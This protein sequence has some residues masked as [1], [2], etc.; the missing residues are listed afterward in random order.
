MRPSAGTEQTCGDVPIWS[1]EM[2]LDDVG[3][4]CVKSLLLQSCFH[5]QPYLCCSH[6]H[7]IFGPLETPI[8]TGK[9]IKERLRVINLGGSRLVQVRSDVD[10]GLCNLAAFPA[11]PGRSTWV[12]LDLWV[13]NLL[14]VKISQTTD[15]RC[16]QHLPI[17]SKQKHNISQL[18]RSA[19][20]SSLGVGKTFGTTEP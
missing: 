8:W 6:G 17:I 2:W 13:M 15:V 1:S 9:M 19:M 12:I 3:W 7:S 14:Q 20:P 4:C 16:R 18:I 10:F 5:H 11:S